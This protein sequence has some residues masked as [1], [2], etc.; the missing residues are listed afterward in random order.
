MA[1]LEFQ[2]DEEGIEYY[3]IAGSMRSTLSSP[4][5][6]PSS[7]PVPSHLI[8]SLYSSSLNTLFIQLLLLQVVENFS[9]ILAHE[10]EA[11][12]E[13]RNSNLRH[14]CT[15]KLMLLIIFVIAFHSQ[16]LQRCWL[17]AENNLGL[18]IGLLY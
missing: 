11:E 16:T 3:G 14:S 18:F 2:L 15:H 7:R 12:A 8:F 9:P 1:I 10:L 5:L 4:Y 17:M 6:N 13:H